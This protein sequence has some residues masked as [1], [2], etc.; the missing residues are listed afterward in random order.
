ME[1]T[2]NHKEHALF[3]HQILTKGSKANTYKFALARFLLDHS[4]KLEKDYIRKKISNQ[5]KERIDYSEIAKHFLKYYW[6]QECK[7]K[8]VQNH[9]PK[10]TPNAIKIIRK[11]F[12][13]EYIPDYFNEMPN[14]II[15]QAESEIVTEVF[16]KGHKSQVVPR[17]Q[18]IKGEGTRKLFYDFDEKGIILNPE[19]LEFFHENY[20]FLFKTVILEWAK[21]LE[22]INTVPR[23]ISKIE[24]EEFRRRTLS[25]F[26]KIF[27]KFHNCFYC[28][29]KLKEGEIHVDHFIP[30][31][32][33]FEDES[34]N[35]VLACKACNLKKSDRLAEEL[36][37]DKL[38]LRNKEN[39]RKIEKLGKS[40]RDLSPEC[41]WESEIK[42]H[43]RN[44]KDYGFNEVRL[45]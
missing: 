43:Y 24:S 25:S 13:T 19:T 36:F 28:L 38:I 6:H 8:I 16:G 42:R 29:N 20:N 22:K 30:W 45:P 7:F 32:Y 31:S 17:F 18:N 15:T 40:L 3:F 44:C 41:K 26:K 23:I 12:G 34:W 11:F 35:F 4:K 10:K 9:D 5:Q 37:L 39:E 27:S 21:F 2:V 1:L 14:E 33:I